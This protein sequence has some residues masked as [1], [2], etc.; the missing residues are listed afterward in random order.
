[1]K[2]KSAHDIALLQQQFPY[3]VQPHNPAC[4]EW[5]Q[6]DGLPFT[7]PFFDESISRLRY[8]AANQKRY[9]RLSDLSMIE[10][11]AAGAGPVVPA[12]IIF[13]VSRCGSPLFSQMLGLMEQCMV[14]AEVPF[15]D[16]LLRLPI[17]HNIISRSTACRL[18]QASLSFY[19]HALDKLPEHVIIKAD[20]WHLHFYAQLRELFPGVP[21]ILLF[22]NPQE[23]LLSHQKRRGI[24]S[25]PGMIEPAVFGFEETVS[26]QTNL[27]AYMARVLE[28]YFTVMIE[29]AGEAR[30]LLINYNEGPLPALKKILQATGIMPGAAAWKRMQERAGFDA[31]RPQELFIPTAPAELQES[32]MQPL[33]QA[34][35]QLDAARLRLADPSQN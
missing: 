21:F 13:H 35:Q 3:R 5:I 30:N 23:V 10:A 28:S 33:M 1:M 25:V 8:S 15:F 4:C 11:W 16:E 32:F 22:R 7:E 20:S 18:Y 19:K 12:A 2:M 26:S 27:D 14:L 29:R 34:Y 31:K 17:K 24:Q 6:H 9:S